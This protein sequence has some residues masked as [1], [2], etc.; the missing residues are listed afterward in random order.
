[1]V[2]GQDNKNETNQFVCIECL[3]PSPT[4][5]KIHPAGL[6]VKL[7]WCSV[8]NGASIRIFKVRSDILLD[9]WHSHRLYQRYFMFMKINEIM[10]LLL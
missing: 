5:Y 2:G 3:A 10:A 6:S 7:T 8:C 9:L 1:M 4:L